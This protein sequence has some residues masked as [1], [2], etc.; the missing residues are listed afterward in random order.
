GAYY[1]LAYSSGA[2]GST[3]SFAVKASNSI[4]T[5]D[6]DTNATFWEGTSTTNT[7]EAQ[8]GRAGTGG[9]S[10]PGDAGGNGVT[11]GSPSPVTYT[12]TNHPGG[13]SGNQQAG[14]SGG[15]GGGGAGGPSG[16]GGSTG[17]GGDLLNPNGGGGG[18][19]AGGINGQ[20]GGTGSGNS[21]AL[22][23]G[24]G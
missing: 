18:G 3:T 21:G 11:N 20:N 14:G 13:G 24:G 6:Q 16:S 7:Y 17:G 15:T 4:T 23:G 8:C 10:A 2:L 5:T 9:A 19:G 22:G 1:G 12:T